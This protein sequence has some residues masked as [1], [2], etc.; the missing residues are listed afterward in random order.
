MKALAFLGVTILGLGATYFAAT[1]Q[2]GFCI[3]WTAMWHA[4]VSAMIKEIDNE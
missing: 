1:D 3:L 2:L 4:A